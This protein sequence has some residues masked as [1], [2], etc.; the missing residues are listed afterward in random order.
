MRLRLAWIIGIAVLLGCGAGDPPTRTLTILHTNDLHARLVPDDRGRGG[1]AEL[2]ALIDRECSAAKACLVLDGG[3]LVQG[4]AVSTLFRGV[5]IFEVANG[6][7]LHASTLGNHEFDYGWRKIPEFLET[8]LFPVVTA[9]VVDS[10]GELLADAPYVVLEAGELRIGVIGVLT[11]SLPHL[12]VAEKYE[13]WKV[14]PV[15]DTVKRWLPEVAKKT[16]L[17]LVLG[18]LTDEEENAI[19]AGVEQIVALVSG[20]GHGGLDRPR[21]LEGRV[22]VRV[23]AYGRELGRL[24]LR[25]DAKSSAVVDWTWKSIPVRSGE[26][27]PDPAVAKCVAHWEK[28]VAESVDVPIGRST[29]FLG[30][31]E[32]RDLLERALYESTGSDLGYV[33]PGG[34][35]DTLPEGP[36]LA[37][38]VW[39]VMPFDN[40]VIVGEFTGQDLPDFLIRERKLDP[41]RTYRL[42]TMDFVATTWKERRSADLD[43]TD[44]G[45]LVRDVVI[46]WIRKQGVLE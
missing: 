27:D 46:E 33:N 42:A 20:H 25:L 24:D 35:R 9:N 18:H 36:L 43:F 32:V 29:R 8:A 41:D 2:A 28:K 21:E 1:F 16:D 4:S 22:A 45:R 23:A 26:V 44:T 30:H 7:G 5:P 10:A 3:D 14:L 31:A 38:H 19:L 11:A 6:L 40:H 39:N 13:P 34:V 37:R 12:T 15:V 17:V